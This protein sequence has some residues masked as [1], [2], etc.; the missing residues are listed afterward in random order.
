LGRRFGVPDL[1]MLGLAL[2]EA[3]T[4]EALE[5]LGWSAWWLDDA[6]TT[7]SARERAYRLYRKRGDPGSAARVAAWLAGDYL[8]FRGEH[9]VANGW[10]RRA[11]RL[12]DPLEQSSDHGWLAFY[13]GYMARRRSEARRLGAQAAELGRPFSVPDLEM[14]GLALEGSALVALAQVEQG[15][16]CLDEAV[17]TALSAEVS[18]L[19]S[20]GWTCCFLI[21]ACNDV[22][23]YERACQWCDRVADFASRWRSRYLHGIC[24]IDYAAVYMSRGDWKRAEAELTAAA[25]DFARSRPALVGDALVGLADLRRRQGRMD[26]AKSLLERARGPGGA[27]LNRAAL[28]LDAGDP[29]SA[30]ELADRFLRGVPQESR[31]HRTT[32][33]ELLVRA[34]AARGDLQRAAS[35]LAELQE[36]ERVVGTR[37]FRGAVRLAEGIVAAA[38]DEHERARPLLEDAVDL[39]RQCGAPFETAQA[40]IELAGSLMALGRVD[41][42]G[43]DARAALDE[44]RKL[45][46]VREAERARRLLEVFAPTGRRRSP[47]SE[48]TRRET[49]VLRLVAEGLTNAQVAQRLVVSEHTVHRHVTNI[50]RKMNLPSR[51]AAAAHAVRLG[52]LEA[53]LP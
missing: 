39:F 7:F 49:E 31:L 27:P 17:A 12:L 53:P 51:T 20:I 5:G 8:D 48:L 14:L 44:L 50:L 47:L 41:A 32:A 25:E 28:A 46:A 21:S 33:L 22:R 38:G 45:G 36:I 1:E 11:H 15:M 4:P 3:E 43:T 18:V 24:R 9:A 52:L 34:H 29:V 37:P 30:A 40:R 42:A 26:E 2:E 23:D 16:R 6:E 19:I 13:E 10:L 35:A